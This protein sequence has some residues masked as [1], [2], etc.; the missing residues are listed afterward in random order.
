[1]TY[2]RWLS[3]G[4]ICAGCFGESPDDSGMGDGDGSTG[5]GQ[6]QSVETDDDPGDEPEGE[7]DDPGDPDPSS[8]PEPDAG[9]EPEVFACGWVAGVG[10][11]AP[12]A[13]LFGS[14][15]LTCS[16]DGTASLRI[17]NEG[18]PTC[19]DPNNTPGCNDAYRMIRISLPPEIREVGTYDLAELSN[20]VDL[21]GGGGAEVE[22][23]FIGT[24]AEEGVLI[25][26]EIGPDRV[27]GY[28]DALASNYPDGERLEGRFAATLCP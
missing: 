17:I 1:M 22:C 25:I 23:G 2:L 13:G 11:P 5:V 27:L 3:A 20:T 10:D 7:T 15:L 8:D 16:D 9:A 26:T 6:T 4:L 19:E 14:A 21:Q 28:V 18:T 12:E 24:Y